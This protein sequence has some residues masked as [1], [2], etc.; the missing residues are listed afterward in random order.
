MLRDSSEKVDDIKGVRVR[1]LLFAAFGFL[2]IFVLC[3]F[4]TRVYRFLR[5]LCPNNRMSC[6]GVYKRNVLNLTQTFFLICYGVLFIIFGFAVIV[7]I[8]EDRYDLS[9]KSKFWIWN[10]N[11]IIFCEGFY[12]FTFPFLVQPLPKAQILQ[13]SPVEFYSRK[14]NIEPY[15]PIDVKTVLRGDRREIQGKRETRTINDEN[16]KTKIE[17]SKLY[18]VIRYCRSHNN[19]ILMSEESCGRIVK[20]KMSDE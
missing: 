19:I 8:Q 2:D 4:P 12:F 6:I 7:F 13:K 10:I 9:S 11:G 5:R 1:K 15:R 17:K 18:P 20:M 16:S 3:Y 14:P